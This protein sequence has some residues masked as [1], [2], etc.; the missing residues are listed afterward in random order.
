MWLS[1]IFCNLAFCHLAQLLSVTPFLLGSV[2][3]SLL[4]SITSSDFSQL[5]DFVEV[6]NLSLPLPQRVN[7]DNIAYFTKCGVS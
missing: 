5:C 6:N 1:Y 7:D 3:N 2:G 4:G